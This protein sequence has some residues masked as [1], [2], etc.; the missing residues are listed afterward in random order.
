MLVDAPDHGRDISH[1]THVWNYS[2]PD[3]GSVG[4]DANNW[5]VIKAGSA[6]AI[7]K[8][9][10]RQLKQGEKMFTRV[11]DPPNAFRC[12]GRYVLIQP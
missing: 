3:T 12:D 9:G 2:V 4:W 6:F 5:P 11:D 1:S 7:E 10:F 8:A